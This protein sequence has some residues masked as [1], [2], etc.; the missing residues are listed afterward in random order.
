MVAAGTALS[1]QGNHEA[2]LVR[3][4]RGANVRV[5]HGLAESLAQL[6]RESEEFPAS[7]RSRSWPGCHTSSPSTTVA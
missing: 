1:V 7:R 4:L 2:K 3:A 6:G 5:A